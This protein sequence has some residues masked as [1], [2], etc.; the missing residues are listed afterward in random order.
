MNEIDSF[1]HF[2]RKVD[3][4]LTIIFKYSVPNGHSLS[5]SDRD[6]LYVMYK[7]WHNGELEFMCKDPAIKHEVI[8]NEL[9]AYLDGY[10]KKSVAEPDKDAGTV[11]DNKE[12]KKP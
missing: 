4:K 11:L 7:V 10:A 2:L 5:N 8:Q 1:T 6:F 9:F 12:S 3:E